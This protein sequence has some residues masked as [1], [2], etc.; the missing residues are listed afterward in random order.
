MSRTGVLL[1]S[2]VAMVG[3]SARPSLLPAQARTSAL[4]GVSVDTSGVPFPF[5][6]FMDVVLANHPM[7]RQAD[8]VAK[9]A[10]A[11]L[12]QAWGAFDPKVVMA[13]DQKRF[14]GTEYYNYFDADL[15]IP[16][17]IGADITV[18]YDR[19]AGRYINPD[20][21]AA[22]AGTVA[23]GISLPLGQRI[24]TDE[25]RTA[26]TQA[27]AA[28]NA[29][30]AER[31]GLLNKL[32][33]R[34]AKDY[35][36]WYE[37]WRRRAI[38]EEGE[39][40]AEFRMRAVRERVATGESAPIDTIEALLEWQRRQVARYESESQLYLAGLWVTSHLW[41]T[42][43]DAA[44]LPPQAK[45]V[46]DGLDGPAL[47]STRLADL[48][49]RAADRHPDLR[50]VQAKAEQARAERLLA[51]QGVLPFAEAKLSALADAEELSALSD[52]DRARE[53][54]KAALSISSSLL[55]L[56]E[57]GKLGASDAKSEWQQL[58]VERV[59]RE[60]EFDVRAAMFDLSNY[61]RMRARQ[62]EGVRNAQL[63]R[64]AEQVRFANG[65]S[66]LLV[67]NLR[68]RLVLDEAAKLAALEGKIAAARGA[69]ALATGN[70]EVLLTG[71]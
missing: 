52:R 67:L 25:R 48:L 24:L 31:A 3:A 65:E 10:R 63:L 37:A 61:V 21:R 41:T 33:Y 69:L 45:P 36:A 9:Q 40:L 11:E 15:K 7:A 46:L 53:N 4:V 59:S 56:K 5:A 62:I 12:R 17:P 66:T 14:G 57:R 30:D 38:A 27:K 39:A 2:C 19:A 55:L 23:A 32:L 50:K 70:P 34:A 29:S 60:V 44:S 71:R 13:W 68:E 8:L 16:L 58:E 43:G 22:G 18:S 28:R 64:D 51:W 6:A 42:G 49:A 54:Y 26:L 35:G 47:D 1:L 20:R